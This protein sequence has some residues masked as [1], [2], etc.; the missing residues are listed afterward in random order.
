MQQR[1]T[2]LIQYAFTLWKMNKVRLLKL[3]TTVPPLAQ[4]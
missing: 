2:I 3:P 4:L 1:L